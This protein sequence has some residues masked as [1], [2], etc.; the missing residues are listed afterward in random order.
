[1]TLAVLPTI[2]VEV[3]FAF[4]AT[5]A[6]PTWVDISP[7]VLPGRSIRR[8][9]S[10]ELDSSET[11]TLSLRLRNVDGRFDP[12]NTAS[13][14]NSGSNRLL[15][16]RPIRV[17]ATLPDG[18]V[19]RRF[20]GFV[21]GWPQ[22]WTMRGRYGEAN[23]QCVDALRA[24]A[25]WK[26]RIRFYEQV[27]ADGAHELYRL[28]EAA[29]P[30]VNTQQPTA[31]IT[32]TLGHGPDSFVTFTA[33]PPLVGTDPG[34]RFSW[35][36]ASSFPQGSYS[37]AYPTD[38]PGASIG[39]ASPTVTSGVGNGGTMEVWWR[40]NSVPATN[41]TFMTVIG[42]NQASGVLLTC[43]CV[44]A[45]FD[46]AGPS[47]VL[48]TFATT[49][50]PPTPGTATTATG[51]IPTAG[52]AD[53]IAVRVTRLTSSTIQYDLIINGIQVA[54]HTE[55]SSTTNP[56]LPGDL[57][58]VYTVPSGF[59]CD[60]GQFNSYSTLLPDSLLAR[61]ASY[62]ATQ[63]DF[64]QQTTGA[65]VAGALDA[66]GWPSAARV[67]D[68]G[69]ITLQATGSIQGQTA[70]QVVQEAAAAELGNVFA[71]GAG[72]IVFVDRAHTVGGSPSFV[73]GDGSGELPYA[74][75]VEL[76]FDEQ[77]IV[78]DWTIVQT[79]SSAGTPPQAQAGDDASAA[80]YFARADSR[81]FPY[82][83]TTDLASTAALLLSRT[84]DPHVRVSGV[85][86][87]V[88]SNPALLAAYAAL[89]VGMYV[90]VRRR[91]PYAPSI[92]VDCIVEQITET[93]SENELSLTLSLS[94][95]L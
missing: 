17:T 79:N 55:S 42:Q 28:N 37:G 86:L 54:T 45:H 22:T 50:S 49:A 70:L 82:A 27:Q 63:S 60:W 90:Q 33:S 69:T 7:Y 91:P 51:V 44:E 5:A 62:G 12:T 46:A 43:F 71:D 6:S 92:L 64:A 8:G 21:L 87:D 1:M 36:S 67:L 66:M 2:T 30:Y 47:Y 25:A 80:A 35:S 39:L 58:A 15:P 75:G 32:R 3:A 52:R 16:M 84:K 93:G 34:V 38:S 41:G 81:T 24:L 57:G 56:N 95:K 29:P 31:S 4:G 85:V 68:A 40:P 61:H 13:P 19:S 76:P 88:A 73:L 18:T 74:S 23:V 72:R 10:S 9:R 65:R 20:T 78:N 14:Y 94:P 83:V 53:H 77:R 11:G 48:R 26:F 59:S 89:E